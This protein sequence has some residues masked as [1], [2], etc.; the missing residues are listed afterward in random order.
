MRILIE[1]YQYNVTVIKDVLHGIDAL[2]NVEGK[3]SIHYVG[4]F[5]N[6]LLRDCVFILPKVLLKDV[7]RQELVFGK[8]RPED[9]TNLDEK[10]PLDS[11]EHNFLYKFAVWVYRAIVVYK[12]DK[13]NDSEIVY[14]SHIARV[15]NG[16]RKLSNT[17]LDILLSLIQFNRD[18]QSFFFFIIKNLHSGLN[19]INWQRT[20]ATQSAIIRE[21]RPIYL[22]PVSKKRQI[23]FDEELL[24]IYVSILNYIG[25]TYGF[26]KEIFCQFQ[27]ITG[28]RFETFIN[29]FGKT[30]LRQIKYKY[31]SDKA[32]QLWQLCYAFFEEARQVYCSTEQREYLL[33]KN[34]HIVFEAIID[35]LI[36]DNPL[37]DGMQ[38][39]QEDGKIVDHLFT[40]QSLIESEAQQIYYIG[41]SKYYKMGHEL[42]SESIYKQYT[43]ARNVIQW[44]LDIFNKE[45][46]P[47]SGVRLRDEVTE[48]YNIIP[49]FFVSAKM[50]E[51]FDYGN[52][53]IEKTDRQK[54]KH[55]Q[56]QFKN[57]LFDRDTLLLFHYDVNFLFVLS[58]YA[59]NNVSQKTDWKENIRKRFRTEI[60]EWLQKDYAF[61]AM[62]AHPDV[63]G[64]EYIR[65]NFKQLLGK[66]YTPFNDTTVYS[67][68]LDKNKV[69]QAD[70]DTLLTELKRFFYLAPCELGMQ[71]EVALEKPIAEGYLPSEETTETDVLM[72]MMENFAAKS[73]NFLPQGKLAVGLK[74]TKD[75]IE[76]AEHIKH[77]GYILFHTR[78]DIDQHLYAVKGTCKI[79]AK[80]DLNPDIYKNVNTTEM[81]IEVELD[82][83]HELASSEIHSSNKP[84]TPTTRYDAQYSSMIELSTKSNEITQ[85]RR[86]KDL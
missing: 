49:N 66:I 58:L 25:D 1:E 29:G 10:N 54:N 50:D 74:Y 86:R 48:G 14:H 17:Y 15:D 3:V 83:E 72:V 79:V 22:N 13:R 35:E 63:N 19:K 18:N 20:I 39:K 33:V 24:V 32:L 28:K 81:Y 64:E 76:I 40:A 85:S 16:Q 38:K 42:S 8:Y 69:H 61:Y 77:V 70:N 75:G 73:K 9:I 27:L 44:N 62:K 12:N 6:T 45:E 56:M 47:S 71:P 84:Y 7:D 65:K 67:L 78:K 2:E 59:R 34:F 57:R 26:P 51:S 4:Y 80:E 52:D 31:F 60:Q 11:N 41:D 53:G 46:T 36:G 23:N 37:P 68:A 55:K 82:A 30:R 21:D 5:Y 43:Y